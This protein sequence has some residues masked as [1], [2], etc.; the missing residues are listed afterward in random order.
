MWRAVHRS[1]QFATL[2]T[3]SRLPNHRS[4]QFSV[5][6]TIRDIFSCTIFPAIDSDV[7]AA[8]VKIADLARHEDVKKS[9]TCAIVRIFRPSAN[10]FAKTR[11]F[12]NNGLFHCPP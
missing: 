11:I 2:R 6:G 10:G 4:A 8:D 5:S 12:V 9:R 3:F 1:V 7:C